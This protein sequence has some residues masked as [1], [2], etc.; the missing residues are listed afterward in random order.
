MC[1]GVDRVVG[2]GER[3]KLNGPFQ[4]RGGGGR[5]SAQG[6]HEEFCSLLARRLK[7]RLCKGGETKWFFL[8]REVGEL[9]WQKSGKATSV[10]LCVTATTGGGVKMKLCQAPGLSGRRGE[11]AAY[12]KD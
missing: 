1:N 2:F 11:G 4:D 10:K 12:N 7:E 5:R 6:R 9:I 8:F 3:S